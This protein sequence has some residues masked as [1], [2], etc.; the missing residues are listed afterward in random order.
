M[1]A[2]VASSLK[3]SHCLQR[4]ITGGPRTYAGKVSVSIFAVGGGAV[5]GGFPP[6]TDKNLMS[7]VSSV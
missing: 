5:V 4:T 6:G 1:S 2:P 3:S 7:C